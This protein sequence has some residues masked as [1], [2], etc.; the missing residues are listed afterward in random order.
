VHLS[1]P[2][3]REAFRHTD[4]IAPVCAA[5]FKGEGARSYEK[6]LTALRTILTNR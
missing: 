2:E 1:D 5:T 6:A 4:V 3:T